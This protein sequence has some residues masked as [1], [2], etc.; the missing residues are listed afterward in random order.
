M[1]YRFSIQSYSENLDHCNNY[2]IGN[3]VNREIH[4]CYCINEIADSVFFNEF[5]RCLLKSWK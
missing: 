3:I 1:R 4:S 2:L 5:W